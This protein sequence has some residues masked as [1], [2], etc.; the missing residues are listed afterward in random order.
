MLA[1]KSWQPKDI[2]MAGK[3][4]ILQSVSG[5]FYFN[6]KAGNGQIILSS[7]M[8][9]TKEGV[10]NAINALIQNA[11]N[12]FRYERRASA[13]G[14]PYFILKAANGLELGRSQMY[15]S[16]SALENGISAVKNNAKDAEI[17]SLA[18]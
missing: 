2:E 7:E 6:L 18:N 4:E 11:S 13:R 10:R 1:E 17:L 12:P 8:F 5:K 15:S 14:N 9:E 3:F 16:A